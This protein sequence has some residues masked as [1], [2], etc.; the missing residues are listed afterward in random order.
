MSNIAKITEFL[1]ENTNRFITITN[2]STQRPVGEDKIYFKDLSN[3]DLAHYIKFHLGTLTA[4]ERVQIEMRTETPDGKSTKYNS[5]P[6]E[7][8]PDNY[9]P[10]RPTETPT[11]T[12][13]MSTAT[14]T[15]QFL[16]NPANGGTFGLGLPQI[17]DMHSKGEAAE[18][19]KK[20]FEKKEKECEEW[21][22]KYDLENEENRR[23]KTELSVSEKK[24]EMEVMFEKLQNKSFLDSDAAQGIIKELPGM[25]ASFAAIKSGSAPVSALGAPEAASEIHAQFI[26]FINDNL[27]EAQV[28]F[29]M[30]ITMFM[31]NEAFVSEANLLT[32]RF[33]QNA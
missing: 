5:C 19:L 12:A 4:P 24:A 32:Q 31:R 30:R 27:N 20:D 22:R 1:K 29:L 33:S 2:L 8:Q 9:Q 10:Q 6:I 25:L 13:T 17:L 7:V 11:P 3:G 18:R 15:P 21:K 26:E 16:G 23:L 14:P 28:E